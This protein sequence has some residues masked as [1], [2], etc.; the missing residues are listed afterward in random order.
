MKCIY[1]FFII[2]ISILPVSGEDWVL[3]INKQNPIQK[4][5]RIMLYK[6][7]IGKNIECHSVSIYRKTLSSDKNKEYREVTNSF[8]KYV[9]LDDRATANS[10]IID[11]MSLKMSRGAKITEFKK[12][13]EEMISTIQNNT[14]HIGFIPVRLIKSLPANI[15]TVKI[16]K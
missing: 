8:I 13:W 4:Y 2:I 3:I 16:D 12:T 1:L 11:Q 14:I 5:T 15:K 10:Y 7:Y 6:I 9:T